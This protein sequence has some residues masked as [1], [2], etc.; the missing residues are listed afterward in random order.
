MSGSAG[1]TG[2][3]TPLDVRRLARAGRWEGSTRGAA[4]G[5]V[6]CNLVVLPSSEAAAFAA[7]CERN[8]GVAPVIARTAPGAAVLPELGEDLDLRYDLPAYSVFEHGEMVGEVPDLAGRWGDDAVGFAFGCSFSLEDALR[9]HGIALDYEARGF[10]GAIYATSRQTVPAGAYAGALVV[11]MRPLRAEWAERAVEVS[12]Q[13]PLLHGAPVH[14]GDPEAL[15]VRLDEPLQSLG[16]LSI[17][18]GEVPVFWACG[19]TTQLVL[20]QARPAWAATHVSAR[21]LVT[22]VEI[23]KMR[24]G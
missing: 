7:W 15:G 4:P 10:G 20:A 21:M 16:P 23:E 6:Q 22:D 18:E 11:S 3:R 8:A 24:V 2:P 9:A 12:R 14:V 19:V 5:R 17:A 1:A 13:Y